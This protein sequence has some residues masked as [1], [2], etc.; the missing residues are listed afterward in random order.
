[1]IMDEKLQNSDELQEN[2]VNDEINPS[3]AQKI[4]KNEVEE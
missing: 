4:R 1:M 2:N 3:L